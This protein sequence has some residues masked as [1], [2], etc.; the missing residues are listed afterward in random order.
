MMSIRSALKILT[1][2]YNENNKSLFPSISNKNKRRI[3]YDILIRDL[4]QIGE[5]YKDNSDLHKTIYNYIEKHFG[6]DDDDGN[7]VTSRP[8]TPSKF[9][10]DSWDKDKDDTKKTST[11][12]S[13]S[14]SRTA[15]PYSQNAKNARNVRSQAAQQIQTQSRM[16]T[17]SSNTKLT[18]AKEP[19]KI[20]PYLIVNKPSEEEIQNDKERKDNGKKGS[21]FN[22][23]W[24]NQENQ[25]TALMTYLNNVGGYGWKLENREDFY[26]R[27]GLNLDLLE[28]EENSSSSQENLNIMDNTK[29]SSSINNMNSNS[30]NVNS[31]NRNNHGHLHGH[32]NHLHNTMNSSSSINT[33]KDGNSSSMKHT[34]KKIK[35]SN[36]T[37]M[38]S[39]SKK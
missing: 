28:E 38:S 3:L 20:V 25:R 2:Y 34:N 37:E 21:L 16:R 31:S 4:R 10:Q 26:G 17:N 15:S 39:I 8:S 7:S 11:R 33:P 36:S 30:T 24:N 6:Q 23:Y 27:N 5:K 22:L 1:M 14:T 32:S 29:S 12:L 35:L 13:N 18:T 9:D 19:V